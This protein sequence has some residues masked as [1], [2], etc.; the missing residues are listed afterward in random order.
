MKEGTVLL[1]VALATMLAPLNSTMIAVALPRITREFGSDLATTGWL[2][3]GYLIVMASLQ[4]IAGKLGDRFGRRW[5]ILGG[6]I[7]F[8]VVS[9][10]AAVTTSLPLL[11]FFRVQQAVAGA[12]ALPNGT[13][14]IREL[15]P[16]KHRASRF[17]LIGALI[18]LAAAGGPPLGGFLIEWG[19]WQA[20]F[21]VNLVFI[22]PALILGWRIHSPKPKNNTK[23]P[24]FDLI[25]SILLSLILVGLAFIGIDYEHLGVWLTLALAALVLVMLVVFFRRELKHPDPVIQLR[26][27][28]SPTFVA[29]AGG[30]CLSNFSMYTTFLIMPVL[31]PAR[32]QWSEAE[33][34]LALTTLFASN[35]ALAPLGGRLA[36]RWGRRWP[37]V[38]GML[39]LGVGLLPLAIFGAQIELWVLLLSLVI[40]GV[41]IGLSS[42]GL[43]TSAV[44]SVSP[45]DSGVASGVFSTSRYFGSIVGSSLLAGLIGANQDQFQGINIVFLLAVLTSFAALLLSFRL[46]DFPEDKVFEP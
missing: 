22:T 31:L 18:S 30:V 29:A 1:V 8:A 40:A 12:L 5:L 35:I 28:R 34:G 41:G 3:T 9:V 11:I 39:F 27:F 25:G 21:Y 17:G 32:F 24:V 7:Y 43:Q 33:V 26:F 46:R 2:V 6:L 36:D 20:I 44:E 4:P 45:K 16:A 19:G 23:P 42:A 13:A 37:T 15:V 14:L 38:I 10:G